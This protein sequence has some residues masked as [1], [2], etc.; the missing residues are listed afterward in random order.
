MHMRASLMPLLALAAS[1]VL[2]ASAGAAT[3]QVCP[4]RS[5]GPGALSRGS[6]AG[7][8]CM[9]RAYRHG[10]AT[11][12]YEL[13]SFG[14]DTIAT[15]RFQLVRRGGSCTIG[16][17]RSFHVVPQKPRVTAVGRCKT[18]RRT[19]TDIVAAGCS[20]SGLAPTASLTRM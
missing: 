6:T 5:I 7:A 3:T 9:L 17:S 15:L 16:V 12:T 18:L 2:A 11:A 1:V 20:G 14:V 10:C 8:E 13:S 19:A 4:A